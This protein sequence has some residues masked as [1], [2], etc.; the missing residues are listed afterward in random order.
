MSL[1]G[2]WSVVEESLVLCVFFGFKK[3]KKE[4][5][6]KFLLEIFFLKQKGKKLQL[7]GCS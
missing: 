5:R 4:K 3:K 2:C 1:M 7:P 6:E